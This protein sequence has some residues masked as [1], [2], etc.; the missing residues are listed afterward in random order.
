MIEQ[1]EKKVEELSNKVRELEAKVNARKST[2]NPSFFS[3]GGENNQK[4]KKLKAKNP[5][6]KPNKEYTIVKKNVITGG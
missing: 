6:R 3:A 5:R 1:L 2:T 4:P